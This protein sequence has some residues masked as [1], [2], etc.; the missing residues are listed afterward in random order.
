MKFLAVTFVVFPKG[1]L[2]NECATIK[3]GS[4]VFPSNGDN[5]LT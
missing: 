4:C 1:L 2:L 5:Y 3:Q